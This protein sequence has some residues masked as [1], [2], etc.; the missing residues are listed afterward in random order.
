MISLASVGSR[1]S[2]HPMSI[3]EVNSLTLREKLQVMETIWADL[4][5]QV[6]RLQVPREHLELLDQ[7]RSR[8]ARGEACLYDWDAVRHTLG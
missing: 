3:A 4:R 6:E 7:R 5:E 8:V 1:I 2:F